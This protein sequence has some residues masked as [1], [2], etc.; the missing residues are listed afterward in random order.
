[1]NYSNPVAQ[2]DA[3]SGAERAAAWQ[4]EV[5]RLPPSVWQEQNSRTAL[6]TCEP[7]GEILG[8]SDKRF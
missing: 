7:D 5:F 1:M 6:V 3:T 2:L 4:H 8:T